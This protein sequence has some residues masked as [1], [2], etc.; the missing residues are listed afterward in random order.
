MPVHWLCWRRALDAVLG[1][2]AETARDQVQQN[3]SGGHAG[4]GMFE[5]LDVSET[6]RRDLR[7]RKD[8][9]WEARAAGVPL[10]PCAATVLRQIANRFPLAIATTAKRAY[11]NA[12]LARENLPQ[13]FSVIVTNEDVTRPKPAPDM[14]N[15]ISRDLGVPTSEIAMVGD[16]AFDRRMAETA[17]SPFLWFGTDALARPADSG[18]HPVASD[19]PTLSR[20]FDRTT[21]PV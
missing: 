20:F 1:P 14:L 15:R 4:P 11:V 21:G 19:W 5:G 2:N 13:A 10:M 12:V 6:E 16:T 7:A 3:L 18:G 8:A 9:L 17:G